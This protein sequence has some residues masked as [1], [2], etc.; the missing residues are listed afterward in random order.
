MTFSILIPT[1][2]DPCYTLVKTLRTQLLALNVE[3]EIIVAD[4]CSTDEKVREENAKIE[5]LSGCRVEWGKENVGRAAIRNRLAEKAAGDW[6]LFVDSGNKIDSPDFMRTYTEFFFKNNDAE[7]VVY[8]GRLLN[9]DTEV[10]NLRYQYERGWE[11][12]GTVEARKANPYAS[13]NTCN[14]FISRT[15]I[16]RLPFNEE[17]KLYGFEDVLLGKQLKEASVPIYHIDNPVTFGKYEANAEFLRKT[18][19]AVR[20]QFDFRELIGDYSNLLCAENR[21]KTF[22]LS[23]ILNTMYKLTGGMLRRNLLGKH[24]KAFCFNLYK[25]MFLNSLTRTNNK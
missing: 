8:G 3:W 21:V 15:T 22:G 4:D 6:L 19:E 5:K 1:Y 25:L 2:N 20:M 17:M 13:F 16:L 10:S 11:S 23:G 14:F 18:E 12:K 24:P 9:D 7:C